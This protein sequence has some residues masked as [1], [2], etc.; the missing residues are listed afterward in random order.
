MLAA[1]PQEQ[2]ANVFSHHAVGRALRV[3]AAS[4]LPVVEPPERYEWLGPVDYWKSGGTSPVWFLADPRRTDLALI[5]PQVRRS[6]MSYRWRVGARHV[7]GGTRP[8][9]ADWYRLVN[10]GWFAGKGWSLTLEAGGVTQATGSGLDH[11][12]IEAYVRRRSEPAWLLI[13]GRDLAAP[14]SAPSRLSLTLDG[15]PLESWTVDPATSANFLRTIALPAGIPAGTGP[16][17]TLRVTASALAPGTPTPP[18]AIRQFNVQSA[19][20]LMFG[21]G[22]GWHEEEFDARTG[23][24][25]RWSSDRSILQIVPPQAV[26]VRLRGESPRKYFD[27][28]L[29]IRLLA[30]DRE[31]A[32][33]HPDAD[34][35]WVVK[36]PAD[37][38]AH[39]EGALTIETDRV[40]LPATAGSSDTR[41]LGVRL[42]M[43]DVRSLLD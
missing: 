10:P 4:P 24:R 30:G 7:V 28:P 18:V 11:G 39:A 22:D 14:A 32:V 42:F 34:F 5:D 16:Y 17:A 38:A 2:P 12:P 20:T 19:P 1:Q 43:V 29:R 31:I 6:V 41:R 15:Q 13:G 25:W 21:F 3:A 26:E 8:I 27:A 36:V 33:L 40:Y 37:A 9:D 35:D 23:E